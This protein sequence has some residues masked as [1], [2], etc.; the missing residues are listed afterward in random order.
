MGFIIF[1]ISIGLIIL[2]GYLFQRRM[3]DTRGSHK[4]VAFDPNVF[5]NTSLSP[6]PMSLICDDSGAMK[7]PAQ[8]KKP[9]T[10]EEK[11][12][13]EK[14]L[15]EARALGTLLKRAQK[16]ATEYSEYV[17]CLIIKA[18]IYYGRDD[19][20]RDD[21]RVM[22]ELGN[23]DLLIY[24]ANVDPGS[25]AWLVIAKQQMRDLEEIAKRQ[26]NR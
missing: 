25:D 20:G 26:W 21:V 4:R 22:F 12:A 18:S 10:K 14:K 17:E 15:K 6:F 9:L 7:P 13:L 16:Q 5:F 3:I 1:C 8:P 23:G 11:E 19:D 24:H 2:I